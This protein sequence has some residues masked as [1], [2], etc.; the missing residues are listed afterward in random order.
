MIKKRV[1]V[2]AQNDNFELWIP[3]IEEE[4]KGGF[5]MDCN[6]KLAKYLED[7]GI[8]QSFVSEKTG[9]TKEKMS[10]ILNGKRKLTGDELV[11]VCKAL[12]INLDYF[13]D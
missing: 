9:I 11:A 7:H 13:L 12:G 8:T 6:M 5:G 10:N 4:L 1:L 2:E 3:N